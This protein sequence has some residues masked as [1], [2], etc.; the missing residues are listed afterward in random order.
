MLL[1]GLAAAAL[2]ALTS[3][4]AAAPFQLVDVNPDA[5]IVAQGD[6]NS[7]G[8]RVNALA[9]APGGNQVAYAASE[10][11]GVYKTSDGAQ[12]WT[13]LGN[14]LPQATFDVAVDPSDADT[15]YAT[16]LYDGRVDPLSGVNISHDGG[17]TWTHAAIPNTTPACGSWDEP[18]AFGIAVV[19]DDPDTV[20]AGTTCGVAV[21]D[22]GGVSWT[23]VDPNPATNGRRIWDVVA[24]AG[25]TVDI[26]GRDGHFRSPDGGETWDPGSLADAGD[27]CSITASPLESDVLYVTQNNVALWESRNGGA[28]WTM[29]E[30]GPGNR[31]AFVVTNRTGDHSFDL[32]YGAGPKLRYVSG[33]D[34]SAVPRCPA[35]ADLTDGPTLGTD[36]TGTAHD[37][38]GDLEFDPTDPTPR[39]PYLLSTDG[40]VYRSDD[41]TPT[42]A[43]AMVGLHDTWLFDLA[44]APVG[45]QTG[46]HFGLM[47][48][49]RW[50]SLDGGSTWGGPNCCDIWDVVADADRVVFTQ[51]CP[52][53]T[54]HQA[55]ANDP[56]NISDMTPPPS[57]W[58]Q[59]FQETDSIQRFATDSY[60]VVTQT[61]GNAL[62][63]TPGGNGPG[64]IWITED[65]GGSYT[66]LGQPT[67]PAG[68]CAVEVAVEGGTPTFY[69]LTDD[70]LNASTPGL[71]SGGG[72]HLF[73]YT[74]TDPGGAWTS[75]DTGL[76]T[77][78]IFGVDPNDPDRL[79]A[80][81]L[82]GSGPR[83]VFST[84]G[85]ASWNSDPALDALMTGDGE[86]AY[87]NSFGPE[88][89]WFT[90]PL[91]GYS[92][93]TLVAF[94]PTIPN[95]L[96]A[97]A[98]D[99]GLFMSS[100]GGAGWARVTDALP[101][102]WHHVFDPFDDSVFYVGTVGRGVWK[103]TVPD[104][105]LSI[106]KDDDPDPAVAGEQLTYTLT[107]ANDGPDD[108]PNV[109]VV[110]TLPDGVDYVSD[111]A[112]CTE[113]AGTV[114]CELGTLSD[115]DTEEIEIVVAIPADFVYEAGGPTTITNTATVA[116]VTIDS[117]P[118]DNTASEDTD[119]VAVADLEIVSFE[120]V[121]P[122]AEILVGV[123]TDVML[124]KVIT[125]HG[126]SAPMD[127]TLTIDATSTP[128]TTVSP[129]QLVFAEDALGLEE[130]REV[131]EIFT[132]E[133]QEAS[134][135][136]FTFDNTIAPANAADT[137]PDLS[138]NDASLTLD[139]V[140]VV[141]VAINIEPGGGNPINLGSNGVIPV[142]VLTTAAGEYGLPLAFDATKIVATTVRFGPQAIVFDETGGAF[143]THGKGHLE[144]SFEL[145]EVTKDADL[146]MVL[147]FRTQET[148]IG[149]NDTQACVK[150]DW[151]DGLGG[152]HKFFGCDTITIVPAD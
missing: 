31:R 97:G 46:L 126:P 36:I 135:H 12:T 95:V 149:P 125:N 118:A 103:V 147:H 93:P 22:D 10:W 116:G 107:V 91:T 145:D 119:V 129:A 39:C 88:V 30:D 17:A 117:D 99:A 105:D 5:S 131:E 152:V 138:N 151:V 64:G 43:R 54:M 78:G 18:S 66:Q 112:G 140:C 109:R 67:T 74:G 127:T 139:V 137:D 9:I 79:Y 90:P 8:G 52:T 84:D 73:K 83:M 15:I 62:F 70:N 100:D 96:I 32:Y 106:A 14:H 38:M 40:G 114:T 85:G 61:G 60:V 4:A 16:S 122:P 86:F 101:R 69:V 53:T 25:G 44:G 59:W 123:P 77:V 82:T 27:V 128:G 23:H 104:G 35:A 141:P 7:S 130:Q 24:Q 41:C 108:V 21:S 26:C 124:R 6:N 71:C 72:G 34:D 42:W 49:G 132:I 89:R 136:S 98:T 37:D 111:D 75:A 1:A 2:L 150:G 142:A 80:S 56:S 68:A 51:C 33:C 11:G 58:L 3:K 102:V 76:T 48:S 148:G 57:G 110:D 113:S 47:D 94:H 55:P 144:R 13:H 146:D 120:A 121:N 143:E 20:V 115:G 29:L 133:C 81:D 65:V 45:G 134:N 28:S 92:Q 19:P 63:E 87:Q 50:F